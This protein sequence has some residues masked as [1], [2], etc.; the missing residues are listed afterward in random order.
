[1]AKKKKKTNLERIYVN[2]VCVVVHR[3]Y[4]EKRRVAAANAQFSRKKKAYKVISIFFFLRKR[5]RK[6]QSVV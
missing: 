2:I 4:K 5:G 6:A 3:K 1:M